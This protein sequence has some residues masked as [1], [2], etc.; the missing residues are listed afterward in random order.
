M[1]AI[2]DCITDVYKVTTKPQMQIVLAR[3][4]NLLINENRLQNISFAESWESLLESINRTITDFEPIKEKI[5]LFVVRTY[6]KHYY[7]FINQL[8]AK[9]NITRPIKFLPVNTEHMAY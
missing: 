5:S 9:N 6:L 3:K 4:L 2:V 7:V 8:L 1:T